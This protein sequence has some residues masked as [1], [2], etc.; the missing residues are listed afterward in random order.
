MQT[1][2]F[3]TF[4]LRGFKRKMLASDPE[5]MNVVG[6]LSTD[7]HAPATFRHE[8]LGFI[9]N[10]LPKWR[11]RP[12]RPKESSETVLSSQLCAH[13]N[14]VARHSEGW[15]MLQ[16]RS[17][18]RD[19]A[20]AGRK[21]DIVPAPCGTTISIEGRRHTDFDAILPIECK[22]LPTPSGGSRDEREYVFSQYSTTGGI[23]RFKAG[24]HGAL[25][26]IAAMIGYIQREN[27]D[28]WQQEV[29]G[30]ISALVSAKEPGWTTKDALVLEARESVKRS[31]TLRS[32]HERA[33]GHAD[34]ELHHLWI[35][36]N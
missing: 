22:R 29:A 10:E 2:R 17:E 24:Q 26:L 36:M 18:E 31:A 27:V 20:N 11:D 13:L 35:E 32:V 4:V 3:P 8:L 30:W 6:S 9:V 23:Q 21:I 7:L 12:D 28:Y 16:F 1:K 5:Q 25:H 14:A 34:I 15:D 19:E 33:N